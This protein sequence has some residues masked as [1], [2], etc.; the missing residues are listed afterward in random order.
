MRL[1]KK[2]AFAIASLL[3][4]I[5]LLNHAAAEIPVSVAVAIRSSFDVLYPNISPSDKAQI[6]LVDLT[7]Y[8]FGHNSNILYMASL[9]YRNIV[10]ISILITYDYD[11]QVVDYSEVDLA[12][13]IS[14]YHRCKCDYTRAKS[15]ADSA[16]ASYLQRESYE[17]ERAEFEQSFGPV[18]PINEHFLCSVV[19]S[20]IDEGSM[21]WEFSYRPVYLGN[22]ATTS[23]AWFT[24]IVDADSGEIIE[25][26]DDGIYSVGGFLFIDQMP[27]Q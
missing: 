6:E 15:I 11:L 26:E 21:A 10:N 1:M 3:L 2:I 19:L 25:I 24:V 4:V 27:A 23:L 18:L 12:S 7:L 14:A 8:P 13:E 9:R 22:N 20:G 17:R 5:V 16:A